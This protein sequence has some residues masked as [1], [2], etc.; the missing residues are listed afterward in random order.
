MS[1][2]ARVI[3]L[4]V[5]VAIVANVVGVVAV[6]ALGGTASRAV[7]ALHWQVLAVDAAVVAALTLIASYRLAQG[8]RRRLY[9]IEEA[10]ALIAAG[11]LHHRVERAG[12]RDEID[13][14]ADQFNQMGE[15]LEQQVGLLQRLAE[16]NRRLAAD[17]ERAATM[18]ERQRLARDLHDS[19]SQ[20]LF[21]LT[22]MAETALRLEA[23]AEGG[24]AGAGGLAAGA[25][26]GVATADGAEDGARGVA[27]AAD[28]AGGI[29]MSRA[30]AKL[31][32][33]LT[34]IADLATSAQ[35]EMRA[36]LLHLRPVDLAGR[37]LPEAASG[38]LRAVEERYRLS[39]SFTSTIDTDIPVLIEE[40]LFR[41]LQEA[42]ANVLKHAGASSI[43]V[44][45]AAAADTYELSVTD[46][47]VG[48][49]TRGSSAGDAVASAPHGAQAP[50]AAG[51]VTDTSDA[52]ASGS[53]VLSAS[54]ADT[55]EAIPSA[56]GDSYGITAMRE[57]A[58]SLGGRFSLLQRRRGTTVTVVIPRIHMNGQETEES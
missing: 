35:R 11:R 44:Q 55:R 32:E 3:T 38:F 7:L 58:E 12:E 43:R 25:A 2:R 46:D 27:G 39:C 57:R 50:D 45:L 52:L 30:R 20:Q 13:Q 18:E 14:L 4:C 34:T 17:A 8:F 6:L 5:G 1:I 36:L 21:A 15:K 26:G 56:A 9:G 29:G 49:S 16:E 42:V 23:K 10:A 51:S 19:V 28:G 31:H 41:I 24:A 22:M 33:T 54:S 37:A 53:A 47:G 48:F 40:H